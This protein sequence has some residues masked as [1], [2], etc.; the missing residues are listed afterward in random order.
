MT[1]KFLKPYFGKTATTLPQNHTRPD[2]CL[3][4]CLNASIV[5]VQD[6]FRMKNEFWIK[7]ARN[8]SFA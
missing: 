8:V 2:V 6:F 7:I 5:T 1:C 4:A 3:G